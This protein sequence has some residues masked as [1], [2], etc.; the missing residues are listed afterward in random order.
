MVYQH[1]ARASVLGELIH[2]IALRA[3]MGG[4]FHADGLHVKWVG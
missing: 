3:C 1:D 2:L 4:Y